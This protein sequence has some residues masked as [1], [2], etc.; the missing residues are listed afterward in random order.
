MLNKQVAYDLEIAE[1]AVKFHR[2][3]L[4]NK[5]GAQS[6]TPLFQFAEK[7]GDVL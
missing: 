3:R 5:T 4:I 6:L 1:K 2:A 7:L